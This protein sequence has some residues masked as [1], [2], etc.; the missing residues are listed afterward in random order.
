MK[1]QDLIWDEGIYPRS[2]LNRKTVEAYVEALSIG[3]QF[4]AVMVQRVVNY[5]PGGD[6]LAIV[7]ILI[8]GVH[9]WHAFRQAGRTDIPVIH[10]QDAVLDYE[11]AKTE[12][13]LE[14]ARNNTSHG[15]RLTPADKKRIA[16]DI[17]SSDPKCRY[18]ETA[19]AEKLGVIQQTVNAWITDIRAR[20]KTNRDSI[21]IR[22][23]RLGWT[24]EKIAQTTQMTQG[25]VAQIINNTIF[26]NINNLLS[27]G[28][29]MTYIAGHYHMEL[30]LAWALRLQG[31]T[32]QEKFKAL[33]W[34]KTP[35]PALPWRF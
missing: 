27:Q 14:S 32:D 25:R 4:P 21:I 5:T 35:T 23:S 20:Q 2:S 26:G 8:D 3:A 18:T 16:R 24:Q 34:G 6:L 33:E 28:R 12:L 7:L 22:L 9:R 1:I 29:D 17:A 10:Y 19:L 30:A 11:A 13:L 15:D 31:K